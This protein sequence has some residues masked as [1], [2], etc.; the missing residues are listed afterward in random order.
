[1]SLNKQLKPKKFKKYHKIKK[2][3]LKT[4]TIQSED[5]DKK[6]YSL[7]SMEN[8]LITVE[9]LNSVNTVLRRGLKKK[10]FKLKILVDFITTKKPIETRMGKGKGPLDGKV[11]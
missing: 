3:G 5:S 6:S 7:V 2:N 8:G 1:M 4:Y 10:G 9:E 11:C